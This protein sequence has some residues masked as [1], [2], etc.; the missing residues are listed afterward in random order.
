MVL[1]QPA[2]HCFGR[3]PRVWSAWFGRH[4]F[5]LTGKQKLALGIMI[6]TATAASATAAAA[7]AAATL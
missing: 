4:A 2:Q 3:G 1:Q 7:A 5:F 6:L